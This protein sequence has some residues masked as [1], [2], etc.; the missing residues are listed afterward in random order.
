MRR[1]MAYKP[2]LGGAF[3]RLM[4]RIFAEQGLIVMDAAAREFH[5][6][7]ASTLRYA[8]EHAAELEEALLA[9]S[10][11]LESGG[12]SCAGAGGGGASLLFLLDEA[13]GERVALRRTGGWCSGR[14]VGGLIRRRS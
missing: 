14:L 3:A 13:T 11:E 1:R 4:A 12:V 5:A 10:E 2:T 9:R 7:G 6:L 8:I